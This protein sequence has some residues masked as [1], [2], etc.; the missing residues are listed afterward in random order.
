MPQTNETLTTLRT[1]IDAAA[2]AADAF[3]VAALAAKDALRIRDMFSCDSPGWH[4]ADREFQQTMRELHI[5]RDLARAS[6]AI[7]TATVLASVTD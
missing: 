4:E 7:A 6:E 3:S 1:A 5:H 2:A